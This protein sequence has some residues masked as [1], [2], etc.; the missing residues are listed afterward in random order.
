MAA[1]HRAPR[2]WS[3]PS[4][5]T[6]GLKSSL[7]VLACAC[8][9]VTGVEAQ[10][11]DT[12][13]HVSATFADNNS[14]LLTGTVTINTATGAIDGFNFVIPSM[15]VGTT[16]VPGLNLT[17]STAT[18]SFG[19]TCNDTDPGLDFNINGAPPGT[20]DLE[21]KMPQTMLVG[22][23]GGTILHSVPCSSQS[24][25]T[26]FSGF[27]DFGAFGGGF[28][29]I[30]GSGTI[31]PDTTFNVSSIFADLNLTPLTG[32]VTINTF[33]GA[34]DGF[35]FNIP[36]MTISDGKSQTTLT[37][38][39]FNPQTATA[40]FFT[41]P[42]EM[43]FQLNGAPPFGETLFLFIPQ[44]TLT[45]YPGGTL[46]QSVFLNGQTFNTGYQSGPQSNPFIGTAG[47]GLISS[48]VGGTL[49][50]C[51]TG[52]DLSRPAANPPLITDLNGTA[53]STTTTPNF[54]SGSDL[55]TPQFVIAGA[56]SGLGMFQVPQILAGLPPTVPVAAFTLLNFGTSKANIDQVQAAFQAI[57]NGIPPCPLEQS[58]G[59]L[60]LDV[61]CSA[62][63]NVCPTQDNPTPPSPTPAQ[64]VA[65]NQLIYQYVQE[66][67]SAGLKPIIYT[68]ELGWG[69]LT[70]NT[71][72]FA[73]IPLWEATFDNVTSLNNVGDLGGWTDG[74]GAQYADN[75]FVL[76][77]NATVDLDAFD[78]SVFSPPN[79]PSSARSCTNS[80]TECMASDFTPYLKAGGLAYNF[81]SHTWNE[82]ITI[83]NP[84]GAGVTIPGPIDVVFDYLAAGLTPAEVTSDTL[85]GV[86][87]PVI[88][89][90]GSTSCTYPN[91]SI[92]VRISETGLNPGDKLVAILKLAGSV[93]SNPIY[94]PR[95]LAGAGTR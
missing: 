63:F 71:K 88:P 3:A 78:T 91:N 32:T 60:S 15:T 28:V 41:K 54:A 57:C 53:T 10:S 9:L 62:T 76:P 25:G 30:A 47:N 38:A 34:I 58:M 2:G 82:Q 7:G 37:G 5:F 66:V 70:G 81:T 68:N 35:N 80:P 73:C 44:S 90:T 21:L 89:F 17:P 14:T 1:N 31:T 79:S 40:G 55:G 4:F 22:Y 84:V 11:A 24:N 83:S 19:P 85:D 23:I 18:A 39:V 50:R 51:S 43:V 64:I 95:L 77:A 20:K 46:L 33:T 59:F 93:T 8:F 48:S 74:I 87:S 75:I 52:I 12:I 67:Q 56:W 13:F 94:V 61:E 65:N 72:A 42:S 45:C 86:L 16:V 36:T 49:A 6:E 69:M 29:T 27:A 92:Y 26:L